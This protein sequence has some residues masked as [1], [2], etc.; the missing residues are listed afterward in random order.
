MTFFLQEWPGARALAVEVKLSILRHL[1]YLTEELVVFAL[2]DDKIQA[3][4]KLNIARKIINSPRPRH[5]APGKPVFPTLRIQQATRGQLTLDSLAGRKSWL[6]FEL[7][8]SDG[9]WLALPPNQWPANQDYQSMASVVHHLQVVNDGAERSIKD[10]QE[11]ADT[12]RDGRHR[13]EILLVA[14][15]HRIKLKA[16]LKNEMENVL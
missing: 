12:A 15:S 10:I 3:D 6:L 4:D 13:G 7:L 5:F 1:W 14:S 16:F 8:E 2:F 11:Y 9:A